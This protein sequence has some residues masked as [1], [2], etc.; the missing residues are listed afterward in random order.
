MDKSKQQQTNE[1]LFRKRQLPIDDEVSQLKVKQKKLEEKQ[2]QAVKMIL[3]GT[4]HL[5]TA[6]KNSKIED[7]VPAQAFLEAGNTILKD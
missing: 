3:E 7:A 5:A 4:E 6:L 2:Q 1:V